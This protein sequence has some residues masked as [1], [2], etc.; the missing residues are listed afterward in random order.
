MTNWTYDNTAASP[1][2]INIQYVTEDGTANSVSLTS[3]DTS[4]TDIAY[5]RMDYTDILGMQNAADV[6][7]LKVEQ[8]RTTQASVNGALV[9]N[10]LSR[11][12]GLPPGDATTTIE[13]QY[14][15]EA[16]VDG[17]VLISERIETSI[18]TSELAGSLAV[19]SYEDYTP[20]VQMFLSTVREL[21]HATVFD[22]A[23]AATTRTTAK[24]WI[25]Y[26]L[27][28]DGQQSFA[29][30]M[31][32]LQSS[33]IDPSEW[34]TKIDSAVE[35][36]KALVFQGTEV[37]T[38][39]GRPAAPTKPSDQAINRNELTEND[40]GTRYINGRLSFISD[41]SNSITTAIRDYVMPF[42]PDDFFSWDEVA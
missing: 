42:A 2:T 4:Q 29:E 1:R 9:A 21:N 38:S 35:S 13:T 16:S 37:Q 11:G 40:T 7:V 17:P 31:R 12:G 39:A 24:T 36:M 3:V 20:G 33:S 6:A 23:G 22:D 19:P 28:Q 15:C 34:G 10:R 18:T 30:Q 14:E 32:Q 25:A 26:G 5:T 27:T 8:R 41:L